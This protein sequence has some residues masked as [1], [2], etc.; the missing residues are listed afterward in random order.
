MD[1]CI[2][3]SS[4]SLFTFTHQV[5]S[6]DAPDGIKRHTCARFEDTNDIWAVGGYGKQ[7]IDGVDVTIYSTAIISISNP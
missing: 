4:E 5:E 6:E 2:L 7:C 3:S 1:P